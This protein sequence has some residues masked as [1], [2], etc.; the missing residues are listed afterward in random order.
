M[1][2]FDRTTYI[3]S[4]EERERRFIRRLWIRTIVAGVLLVMLGAGAPLITLMIMGW[5]LK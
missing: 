1:G 5:P 3:P 4:W 2:P